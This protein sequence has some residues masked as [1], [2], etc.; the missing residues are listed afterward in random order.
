VNTLLIFGLGYSG[1]AVAD[2]AVDFIVAATTR[3]IDPSVGGDAALQPIVSRGAIDAQESPA[4]AP[5]RAIEMVPFAAAEAAIADATH[6]LVTAPPGADGDPVLNRYADAIATAPALRWIGYLSS[7]V[8]YGD[9]GGAWV[10]EATPPAPS[11]PRGHRRLEAELAWS[12]F[13][14]RYAIDLFR[15]A[16]IYG[17][18][19]SAFDDLRSGTARRMNKPGHQ[20]GRI[21]RDD[22][23]RAIAVAMQQMRDPGVRVLNLVDDVPVESAAVVTEAARLLG[24]SP[25]PETAFADALPA[26]SPMARSFWAENRKVS[27]RQTQSALG[28]RW[29]YPSFREGLAAILREESRQSPS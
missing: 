26:M 14:A 24:L 18:G 23:G 25:P 7:T 16:G 3:S 22:I 9:R 4:A 28:L 10:D 29:L 2:S 15:L 21:H 5:S 8:V 19:R 11:Q 13:A 20:F 6:I 17:P 1:R 27:G 12:R